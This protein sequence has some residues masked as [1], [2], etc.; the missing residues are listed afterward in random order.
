L[1]KPGFETLTV[2]QRIKAP[3]YQLPGLDFFS[4]HFVPGEIRDHRVLNYELKPAAVVP[5]DQ[6]LQR[7][8]QLRRDAKA[9]ATLEQVPIP[10][11][12]PAVPAPGA[13]AP[14]PSVP[15][16]AP[17]STVPLPAPQPAYPFA[18]GGT[19]VAPPASPAPRPLPPVGPV[20]PG[21]PIERLPN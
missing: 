19:S 16:P 8:E 12:L 20:L 3:W 13:V 6:L 21:T 4:E 2:L 10:A 17:Q 7:G 5:T 11:P 1:I 9:G 14:P 18:P 15:L